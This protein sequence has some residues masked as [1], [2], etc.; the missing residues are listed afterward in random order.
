MIINKDIII[1]IPKN[2]NYVAKIT[3]D[4]TDVTSYAKGQ[5]KRCASVGIGSFTLT[6]KNAN[7]QWSSLVKETKE[8]I[9]YCDNS[10]GTT[11]K[12][13]GRIDYAK[14]ELTKDGQF[15]KCEG[16]HAS[17]LLTEIRVCYQASGADHGN[18]LKAIINQFA[19][20]FTYT[21]VNNTG[22]TITQNWDYVPFWEV[23]KQLCEDARFDCYVDDNLDFHFFEENSIV[24]ENE[25]MVEGMNLLKTDEFGKDDFLEKSVITVVGQ[26]SEGNAII[27][28]DPTDLDTS[29][30]NV[31]E[32]FIKDTSANTREKCQII[33]ESKKSE[34]S[35]RPKQGKLVSYYLETL[36]P[37]ENLLV[38]IPRQQIA[39]YYK[40]LQI[41]DIF[42]SGPIQSEVTLE[43]ETYGNEQVLRE[44]KN[45]ETGLQNVSNPDKLQQ[46]YNFEF[47]D[48][49]D[50]SGLT[51]AELQDGSLK[52][53][54]GN[55][56]VMIS[57]TRTAGKNI[58]KIRCEYT[59]V[60]LGICTIEV[61]VDGGN[62]YTYL[63]KSSTSTFSGTDKQLVVRATLNSDTTNP[64]PAMNSLVIYYT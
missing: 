37:G 43:K 15:I 3:I 54:T 48:T 56:G 59:G 18:V 16:R 11:Q 41:I 22:S 36:V 44:I 27:Y 55:K 9:F 46:S 53:S 32:Y 10:A 60:D 64:N 21:N 26:D 4:G 61:S 58:T 19:P 50:I 6:I 47:D 1:P 62:S 24:N 13:K 35:N 8:V 23:V 51:D 25:Y 30:I 40:A 34:L 14:E 31:R 2:I 57:N 49:T 38:L 39:L 20:N 12:F 42:G 29:L 7:G 63:T 28:T 45:R 52:I 5:F 33:A 17:Y